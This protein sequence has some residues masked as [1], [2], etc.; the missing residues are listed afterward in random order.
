MPRVFRGKEAEILLT[1]SFEAGFC[2][3]VANLSTAILL[4]IVKS[5]IKTLCGIA[6]TQRSHHRQMSAD[7]CGKL[8]NSKCE[9]VHDDSAVMAPIL[10]VH[11]ADQLLRYGIR[12]M[13]TSQTH[14]DLRD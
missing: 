2:A 3:Q 5:A 14:R 7:R 11:A 13:P 10:V 4:S 8:R 6:C 1:P 12:H 9:P